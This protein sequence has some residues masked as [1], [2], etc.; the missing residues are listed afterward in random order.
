MHRRRC[1]LCKDRAHSALGLQRARNPDV[2]PPADAMIVAPATCNTMAKWAAGISD[3]L[4]LGLLV[5]AVGK[6]LPIVCMPFSNRAQLSFPAIQA[7]M[8]HL[9]DW[10]LAYSEQR[11][12]HL[13]S[14][15]LAASMSTSS[16]G[17]RRGTHSYNTPGSMRDDR[18]PLGHLEERSLKLRVH[19]GG[20]S[21]RD[22]AQ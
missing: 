17:A 15:A 11:F 12:T 10:G 13:T 3:T 19:P 8:R 9:A 7:A 21:I 1:D 5:E 4:P 16:P 2:L 14:L 22:R 18:R 6:R 20:I